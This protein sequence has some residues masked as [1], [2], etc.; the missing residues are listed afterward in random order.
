M[1]KLVSFNLPET[2]SFNNLLDLPSDLIYIIACKLDFISLLS[3]NQCSKF[4]K[5]ETEVSTIWRKLGKYY[6]NDSHVHSKTRFIR[7]AIKARVHENK[8]YKHN[9]SS[10]K[11]H[12][13]TYLIYK[14]SPHLIKLFRQ[15]PAIR[16]IH[17]ESFRLTDN[18]DVNHPLYFVKACHKLRSVHFDCPALGDAPL[19]HSLLLH[20]TSL[21][22]IF[23]STPKLDPTTL[24]KF[25]QNNPA[26]ESVKV[27]CL[28]SLNDE[29]LEA[30]NLLKYIRKVVLIPGKNSQINPKN[31]QGLA[32][33]H[34]KLQ[35]LTV[36]GCSSWKGKE[37]VYFLSRLEQVTYLSLD[38][39]SLSHR[40]LQPIINSHVE[41]ISLIRVPHAERLSKSLPKKEGFVR[42]ILSQL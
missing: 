37:F 33:L 30:L 11:Y 38:N 16:H 7:R 4:T 9:P 20:L 21:T 22:K 2:N 25:I 8:E 19:V 6:F 24:I 34:P 18:Q 26:L 40:H 5:R 15:N 29:V 17:F 39:V 12:F 36:H 13:L 42:Q 31:I 28:T 27:Y 32:F 14:N 23:L 10:L 3:L 35:M 41:V 1:P